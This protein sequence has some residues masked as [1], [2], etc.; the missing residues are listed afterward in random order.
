MKSGLTDYLNDDKNNIIQITPTLLIIISNL[1]VSIRGI[2]SC[3]RDIDK[4][5]RL[6]SYAFNS[7]HVSF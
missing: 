7:I 6:T 5:K 3:I 2:K 1:H 4:I